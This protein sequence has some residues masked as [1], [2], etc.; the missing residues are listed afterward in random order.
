MTH[1][2]ISHTSHSDKLG[3]VDVL[4]VTPTPGRVRMTIEAPAECMATR[5]LSCGAIPSPLG[6]GYNLISQLRHRAER[7]PIGVAMQD[8]AA[9][10]AV[11]V[12]LDA[13]YEPP[14][15]RGGVVTVS[16]EARERNLVEHVLPLATF[17]RHLAGQPGPDF[18]DG[19]AA[20]RAAEHAQRCHDDT[21]RA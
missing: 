14:L 5:R 20:Y 3:E 12:A 8:A 2:V 13:M 10:D 21:L 6:Y 15:A 16:D 17:G 4:I 1:A 9:G 7:T 11:D 18:D 19:L